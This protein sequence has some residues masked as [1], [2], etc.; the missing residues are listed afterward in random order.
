MVKFLKNIG[1]SIKDITLN[2]SQGGSIRFLLQKCK[3]KSVSKKVNKFLIKESNSVLYNKKYINEWIPSIKGNL[4]KLKD[5][6]VSLKKES[7]HIIGYGAPTKATLLIEMASLLDNEIDFILE[8][9]DL[10]VGKYLPKF[11]IE[12]KSVRA[13]T[14]LNDICIIIFAWNFADDIVKKLKKYEKRLLIV[15]P[16]P[17][18]EIIKL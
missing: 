14:N 9:N 10:K 4:K 7:F 3:V 5:Y 12:I 6:V 15:K 18:F 2:T 1:F 13:L 11:G 8:D 16:L 17:K